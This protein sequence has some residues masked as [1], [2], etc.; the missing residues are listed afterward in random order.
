MS[1]MRTT[2]AERND[3]AKVLGV[4]P[5]T[6]MSWLERGILKSL[7]PTEIEALRRV[8]YGEAS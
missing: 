8:I 5:N 7:D 1:G 3:A 6:V 4:H 2:Q